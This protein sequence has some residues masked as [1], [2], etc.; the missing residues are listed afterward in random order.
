[1]GPLVVLAIIALQNTER[2]RME[3]EYVNPISI[4]LKAL[5]CGVYIRKSYFCTRSASEFLPNEYWVFLKSSLVLIWKPKFKRLFASR[6]R[7]Q[8]SSSASKVH[9]SEPLKTGD[10]ILVCIFLHPCCTRVLGLKRLRDAHP[11][12]P[13]MDRGPECYRASGAEI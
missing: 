12:P 11:D 6:L 2:N 9:P 8:K 5:A 13:F 7:M 4:R 3:I 1:M 10:C